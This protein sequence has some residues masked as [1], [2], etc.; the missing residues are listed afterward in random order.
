MEDLK[1]WAAA[2][3]VRALKTAAQAA[4][5]A[6]GAATALGGVDWVLVVSTA[7]LAAVVSV[8]TSIAGIPEVSD[9]ASVRQLYQ[10]VKESRYLADADDDDKD[11]TPQ[12][13]D[14]SK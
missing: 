1:T 13:G 3:G 6:I 4:I 10:N 5:A 12:A 2:A 11:N 8:L 9:G 14:A 7:A